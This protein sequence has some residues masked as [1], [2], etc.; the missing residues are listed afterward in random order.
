MAAI[1]HERV[2]AAAVRTFGLGLAFA[3]FFVRDVGARDAEH[4]C[5]HAAASSRTRYTIR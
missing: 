1:D 4:V 3:W 2:K 5:A